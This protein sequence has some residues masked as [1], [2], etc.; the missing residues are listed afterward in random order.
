MVLFVPCFALQIYWL[1]FH[2]KLYTF[3]HVDK[4]FIRG[5]RL[6][7]SILC[8][9]AF[10]TQFLHL[11]EI[12]VLLKQTYNLRKSVSVICEHKKQKLPNKIMEREF[13]FKIFI[14]GYSTCQVLCALSIYA[15][16]LAIS[17]LIPQTVFGESYFV[18]V[19]ESVLYGFAY[20]NNIL[21]LL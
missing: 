11:P 1:I 14:Y 20:T 4:L 3:Y 13:V 15:A 10:Y 9:A 18:K 5:I 6:F 8:F 17:Y 2:W 12:I 19:F 16:S 21:N 7:M